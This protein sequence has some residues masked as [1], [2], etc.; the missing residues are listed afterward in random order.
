MTLFSMTK[1]VSNLNLCLF[2]K[3]ERQYSA[4]E[5]F[6]RLKTKQEEI[7]ER[8]LSGKY[9]RYFNGKG[10]KLKVFS[11]NIYVNFLPGSP[12]EN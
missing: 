12:V 3:M 6:R 8:E 1:L 7:L 9:H 2:L 10:E 4:E 5:I 11:S